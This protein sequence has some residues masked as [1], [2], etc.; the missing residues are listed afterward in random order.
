MKLTVNLMQWFKFIAC[1]LE[2]VTRL[3]LPIILNDV[4]LEIMNYG[5]MALVFSAT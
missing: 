4:F 2:R 5:Q 1:L 3:K